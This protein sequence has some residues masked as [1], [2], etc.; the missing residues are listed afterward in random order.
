MRN[1]VY[2]YLSTGYISFAVK[3]PSFQFHARREVVAEG[4]NGLEG[5]RP[6]IGAVG[7]PV[8]DQGRIAVHAAVGVHA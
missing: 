2:H 7:R 1:R 4:A 5:Q 8:V 6:A 3:Y